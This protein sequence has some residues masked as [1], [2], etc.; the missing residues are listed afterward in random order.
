MRRDLQRSLPG[1][2]RSGLPAAALRPL[3]RRLAAGVRRSQARGRGDQ[4]RIAT[5]L[6]DELKL[7]LSQ[8]KTLITHATSQAARFLGYEIRAQHCDT[9]ISRNRRA[10]NASDR[11]VRAQDRHQAAVRALHE[12]GKTGAA[13]QPAPRQRLQ[14]RREVRLRVRRSS[15]STTCWPRMCSV[16]AACAG[17]WKP[18]CSRRWPGST[19]ARSPGWLESTRR[20]SRHRLGRARSFRSAWNAI[21]AGS[22]WSPASAGPRSNE[23]AQPSS[24]TSGQSWPATG[25]TS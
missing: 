12:Q 13:R 7:E 17:S 14:H 10:V 11:V 23:S 16:W 20:R 21:G 22:H 3:R 9:K 8:S 15:S 1:P 2:E 6:R 18:P 4:A 5:F 24:P 25:A 19:A